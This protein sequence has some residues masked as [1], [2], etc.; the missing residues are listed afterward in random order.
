MLA[1]VLLPVIQAAG[2]VDGAGNPRAG[3]ERPIDDV[4][5]LAGVVLEHVDDAG[6]AEASGV[7]RLAA[8]R[9]VEGGLGQPDR[10]GARMRR[11]RGLA[12]LHQGVERQA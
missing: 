9:R 4:D 7:E 6:L 10:E 3:L 1:A 2:G 8:A 11:G 5:D 12:P